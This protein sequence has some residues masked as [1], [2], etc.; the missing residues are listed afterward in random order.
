MQYVVIA[1]LFLTSLDLD[2]AQ[3][4]GDLERET[5][6][7]LPGVNLLIEKI[8]PGAQADGL[9]PERIQTAAELILRSSDIRVLTQKEMLDSPASPY[10]YVK[11]STSKN[12][13]GLYSYCVT[14]V[15]SQGVFLAHRPQE[16]THAITWGARG[17]I[18]SVGKT[19]LGDSLTPEVEE[20]VKEFANDFLA[21]N[22]R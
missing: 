4:A 9:S 20:L 16:R 5:L 10:L 15:L 1:M 7:G 8:N 12:P 14:A 3:A 11:V 6:R 2:P 22:P 17:I 18:G 19:N 13:I 21:V